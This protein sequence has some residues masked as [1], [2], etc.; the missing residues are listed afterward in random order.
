MT[1]M[2]SKSLSAGVIAIAGWMIAGLPARA[3]Q[4]PFAGLSGS[5]TGSGNIALSDG[6]HNG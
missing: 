2:T 6:S 3:Q 4:A 1:M 5:W